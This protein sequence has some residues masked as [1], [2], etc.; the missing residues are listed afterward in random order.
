MIVAQRL[1]ILTAILT[2]FLIGVGA[3]V[4]ATGSGLG[5]PDW[6]LC[7]GQAIPPGH[8]EAWIEFS[9]RFV[10][11]VVG[12]LVIAVAVMAWKYYRHVPLI[13]WLA[14]ATVPLVG[15]QGL[16]GAITVVRELP[17]E[18]VATHLVTAMVVLSCVIV[19]AVGMYMEDER[20]RGF[21]ERTR[22]IGRVP[23]AWALAGLGWL[24]VTFW[25][26]GYMAESGAATACSGWPLCNGG[27]LPAADD[28]EI[29]HMLH[30]YLA[31]GFVFLVVPAL[32]TA[33]RRRGDLPWAKPY[34]LALGTL[35]A[36][37]VL[38]GALNVWYT[39]PDPLT[40][41]HT[42][43]AGCIWGVLSA[44]AALAFYEPYRAAAGARSL[45][46]AEAPA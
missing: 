23:G 6:P 28:Q 19:V 14:T 11:S 38:V 40:V 35:Y 10:A 8:Q 21:F 43:I 18:I 2:V 32:V 44:G 31:G 22:G 5:C 4:R 16:L 41:A 15:F 1:A 34:A 45:P 3:F 27:V 39:F 26:G 37:Q 25:V 7:H 42:A 12:V 29:T 9:H 17:P 24:A 20:H 30:R 33:W 46:R 13:T 36:A